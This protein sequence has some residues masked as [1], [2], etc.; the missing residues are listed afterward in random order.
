M[1][2][3]AVTSKGPIT[4]SIDVRNSLSRGYGDRSD[5]GEATSATIFFSDNQMTSSPP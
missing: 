5:C 2:T 4:P 1:A 3:A